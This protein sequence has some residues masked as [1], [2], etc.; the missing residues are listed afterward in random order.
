MMF[1]TLSPHPADLL[2][3]PDYYLSG[4]SFEMQ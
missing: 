3:T 4:V 1:F 2:L